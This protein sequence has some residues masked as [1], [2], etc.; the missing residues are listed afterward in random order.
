MTTPTSLMI[1]KLSQDLVFRTITRHSLWVVTLTVHVWHS[2][3]DSRAAAQ[4]AS[5][6]ALRS[7]W[8]NTERTETGRI[9]CGYNVQRSLAYCVIQ[10]RL[11]KKALEVLLFHRYVGLSN[12]CTWV[13]SWYVVRTLCLSATFCMILT[14]RQH[15]L[16]QKWHQMAGNLTSEF[17]EAIGW[18]RNSA[19]EFFNTVPQPDVSV[20]N[21]ISLCHSLPVCL[22]VSPSIFRPLACLS[23]CVDI[24]D[25]MYECRVSLLL[26]HRHI[27]T[28]W[29]RRARIFGLYSQ[30]TTNGFYNR[31][32]R[33]PRK[34]M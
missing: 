31:I 23:F 34:G 22:S 11:E 19:H 32:Q 26:F 2:C 10:S 28:D 6:P 21:G 27:S 25:R 8:R 14:R 3:T 12:R 16:L 33:Q 1:L 4:V 20:A 13:D 15:S 29:W 17:R 24:L 9:D 30:T 18:N 5:L 7:I